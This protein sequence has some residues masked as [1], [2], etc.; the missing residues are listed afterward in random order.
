MKLFKR[1]ND[2]VFALLI[3]LSAFAVRFALQKIT[4]AIISTS[5]QKRKPEIPGIHRTPLDPAGG[6]AIFKMQS[7]KS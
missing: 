4:F 6:S 1:C 3:I 5:V 7:K 2:P